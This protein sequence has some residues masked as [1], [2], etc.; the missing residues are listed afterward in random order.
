ML[1]DRK[2]RLGHLIERSGA[3]R[4]QYSEPFDDGARLLAECDRVVAKHRAGIYRSGRSVGWIKVK[5][6]AWRETNRNR[7]ELFG[8]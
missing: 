5:C 2:R 4:L 6:P 1:E 7:G 8:E 3:V